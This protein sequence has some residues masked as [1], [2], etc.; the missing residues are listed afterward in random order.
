M[1]GTTYSDSIIESRAPDHRFHPDRLGKR[2]DDILSEKLAI[3]DRTLYR[4]GNFMGTW[5]QL[6]CD[7]LAHEYKADVTLSPGFR[8]GTSVLSGQWI[9]M[10]DVMTQTA[11]TYGETYVQEMSGENLMTVLE[12]VADNLFDPDPY[13]QSGG[14]MVRV[15]GMDYTIDPAKPLLQ[16][17]SE[18]VLDSGRPIVAE[19][20]YRVAG[21]GVVG[22]YPDGPLDLGRGEGLSIGSARCQQCYSHCKNEPPNTGWRG[23][24]P[25]CGRLPG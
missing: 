6:I 7:A 4:R 17:I 12:S 3:A 23:R 10:E 16:R 13:F 2:F 18:A 22:D 20:T 8:W 24:Q 14:D 1:R 25:G 11:M 5:D 21:W 19:E 15:G 9:T